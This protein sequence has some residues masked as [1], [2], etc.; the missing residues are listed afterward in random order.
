VL[1]GLLSDR[2]AYS[3]L[4][5]SAEYLPPPGELLA[6]LRATGFADAKRLP[7]T[8]GITQLLVATRT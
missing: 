6:T 5:R 2:E 8:G 1:G 3:Y 7:L 4:P